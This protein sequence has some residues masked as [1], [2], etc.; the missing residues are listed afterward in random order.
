VAK[1]VL[2]RREYTEMRHWVYI[3]TRGSASQLRALA[4][5]GSVRA[6]YLGLGCGKGALHSIDGPISRAPEPCG[7][8][9]QPDTAGS[10]CSRRAALLCTSSPPVL[11]LCGNTCRNCALLL[12]TG[13]QNRA[14]CDCVKRRYGV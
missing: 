9:A 3:V 1:D 8:I 14:L 4:L 7:G 10:T 6:L 11:S 13:H 5:Y 12:S 2:A